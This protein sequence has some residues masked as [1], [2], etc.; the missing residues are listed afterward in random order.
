MMGVFFG[1][2]VI[3]FWPLPEEEVRLGHEIFAAR[4]QMR[5]IKFSLRMFRVN[6]RDLPTSE[7]GLAALFDPPSRFEVRKNF[8]EKEGILDP[9][10]I[11]YG[12]ARVEQKNMPGFDIWSAG[13]DK[14]HFT[15]D[16]IIYRVR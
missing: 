10:D 13:P 14:F 16:D 4:A 7:E 8:I 12:Y 9:W 1:I 11:P 3:K 2:C 6:Q 5:S 15:D